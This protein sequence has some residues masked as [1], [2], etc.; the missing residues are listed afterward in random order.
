MSGRTPKPVVAGTAVI[1]PP[2]HADYSDELTDEQINALR[3]YAEQDESKM[4][5]LVYE[6]TWPGKP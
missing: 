6:F 4:G 1:P 3:E 5:A 2:K